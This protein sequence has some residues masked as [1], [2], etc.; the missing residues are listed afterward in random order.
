MLTPADLIEDFVNV[1][2]W[3]FPRP[4]SFCRF[5]CYLYNMKKLTVLLA[6]VFCALSMFAQEAPEGLFLNSKAPDF[7][8]K[9]Q[10][11]TEV[12]LKDLV[13]KNKVVLI[14]YRGEWTPYCI[15]FLQKVQDSLSLI[16]EK[17]G[18]VVAV[19]PE[20]PESIA[21]TLE[22]TKAEFPV[23]HDV[24]I[25]IMKAYDVEYEVPE[26]T[27]TRYRNSGIKL[28]EINGKNGNFLPVTAVYIIDKES[29]VVYRFFNQDY[30][31]RPSIKELLD[32]L[33]KTL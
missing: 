4:S 32:F 25:K 17:G 12:R 29:S 22:K 1:R 30:K 28:D 11:G 21:K 26:N 13:K 20:S 8:A 27:L 33:Q 3:L 2:I 9:D 16:K 6:A 10:H 23:I 15:S 18:T 7:K 14:F 24:D 19:T 31:K 5:A